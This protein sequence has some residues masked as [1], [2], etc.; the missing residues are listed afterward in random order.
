M[1]FSLNFGWYTIQL[2]IFLLRIE[3]VRMG[4][5]LLNRQNLLNITSYLLMV[6]KGINRLWKEIKRLLSKGR[7][8]LRKEINRLLLS[9]GM[10]Y[11]Y[12]KVK[13]LRKYSCKN[14]PYKNFK[15]KV[16]LWGVEA[17]ERKR[18]ILSEG[19]FFNICVS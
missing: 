4:G 17:C 11:I 8:R 6:P 2:D 19:I 9:K 14:Y 18:F 10:L 7:N 12:L 16:K 3:E 1:Y 5:G 15:L 13:L